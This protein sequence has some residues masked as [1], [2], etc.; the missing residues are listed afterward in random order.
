ME[1]QRLLVVE[2]EEAIRT[3]LAEALAG[4]GF[5][6][7]VAGSAAQALEAAERT[8]P[9]LVLLDLMLPDGSGFEVCRRLRERGPTPIIMLTARGTK[10]IASS[11]SSSGPTTTSSSRSAHGRSPL[12]FERF[13]A[14]RARQSLTRGKPLPG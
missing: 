4:E 14:G 11:V 1:R 9:D 12:G 3:P 2:D 8:D 5:A 13:S 7:E 6:V 10:R